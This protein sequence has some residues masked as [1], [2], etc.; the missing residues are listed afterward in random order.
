MKWQDLARSVGGKKLGL[1]GFGTGVFTRGLAALRSGKPGSPLGPAEGAAGAAAAGAEAEA[2]PEVGGPA[3]GP[4]PIIGDAMQTILLRQIRDAVLGRPGA[5][6]G[7]EVAM[8][9]ALPAPPDVGL[10]PTR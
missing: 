6:A 7:P 2:P 8:P 4:I 3:G 5:G 1:K 10:P 9:G